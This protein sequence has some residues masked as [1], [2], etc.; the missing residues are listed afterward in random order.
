[1]LIFIKLVKGEREW[2][3]MLGR[4][5]WGRSGRE[6]SFGL[7]FCSLELSHVATLDYEGCWKM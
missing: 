3:E 5:T 2:K 1:M 4:F 7:A 6:T